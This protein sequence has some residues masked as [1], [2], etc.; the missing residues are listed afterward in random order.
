[1]NITHFAIPS[2]DNFKLAGT[3]YQ[4][5]RNQSAVMINSGTGILRRYYDGFARFLCEHGFTVVTYDYRGIGDSRPATLR[6]F[7]ATMHEWGQKDMSGVIDWITSKIQPPKLFIIGHSAGGQV[8]GLAANID[9]AHAMVFVAAQSG[10]WRHWPFP[11]RYWYAGLWRATPVITNAFGYLPSRRLGIGQDLP[12][13]VA[14]EWAKWCR[15]PQYLFGYGQTLDLTHYASF[16]GPILA[17]SFADDS[18]APAA[19]VDALLCGYKG[20]RVTRKHIAPSSL[21]VRR[22]GHFGFFR[23][24]FRDTLWR[25]TVD[26]LERQ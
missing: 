15:H 21:N 13:G 20:A 8:A 19:A 7:S 4:A 18:Y 14:C 3:L 10:Y 17:Y 9:L 22:I 16:T 24:T 1:M 2:K 6:G 12:R 26:W 25:D 5:E 11:L 23:E